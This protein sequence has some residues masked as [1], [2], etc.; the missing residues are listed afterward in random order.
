MEKVRADLKELKN[1]EILSY[2]NKQTINYED[3]EAVYLI[4]LNFQDGTK[5][6]VKTEDYKFYSEVTTVTGKYFITRKVSEMVSD[7]IENKK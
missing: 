7:W 5:F 3:G 2:T 6:E 4:R 1:K